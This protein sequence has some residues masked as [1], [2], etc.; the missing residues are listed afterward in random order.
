LYH[1]NKT[2]TLVRATAVPGLMSGL[3]ARNSIRLLNLAYQLVT[4]SFDFQV[5]I[6]YALSPLLLQAPCNLLHVTSHSVQIHRHS[7][8][9]LDARH[10]M[11]KE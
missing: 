11:R 10:A 9:M 5:R 2:P 3:V 8:S 4:L 7:S 1:R 6:A